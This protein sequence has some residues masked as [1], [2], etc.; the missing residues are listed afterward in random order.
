MRFGG[1]QKNSLIDFPG[2][3]CCVLFVMGCNFFCPYCHNPELVQND[4]TRLSPLS[5]REALCFLKG[6]RGL[7]DGVTVSGGEPTLQRGLSN[8]LSKVKAMGYSVKLDT[9]G[10]RPHVLKGLLEEG[11]LD[12]IAMDI[13]TAP[14]GYAPLIHQDDISIQISESIQAILTAGVPHEFRTTC[15]AP[16][17]NADIISRIAELIKGADLYVLQQLQPRRVLNPE[18]IRDIAGRYTDEELMAFQQILSPFVKRCMI[19]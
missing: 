1:I 12:Y 16:F 5:E 7:L 19:R 6:R 10:S 17:V 13:K 9:N 8:F 18:F 15:L 4:I 11:L 3:I 2:N 14:T